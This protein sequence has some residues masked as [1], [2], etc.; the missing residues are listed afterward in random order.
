MQDS[1][2]RKLLRLHHSYWRVSNGFGAIGTTW[3]D[4]LR[5]IY[6]LQRPSWGSGNCVH[7]ICWS[8]LIHYWWGSAIAPLRVPLCKPSA[9]NT[10]HM[11]MWKRC[12][13]G[14]FLPANTLIAA[15]SRLSPTFWQ[16]LYKICTKDRR[17]RQKGSRSGP[18]VAFCCEEVLP[19]QDCYSSSRSKPIQNDSDLP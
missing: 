13:C 2:H 19:T 16:Q 1:C 11:S 4:V 14:L 5:L 7:R 3:V 10:G 12:S 9:Q 15:E 8:R 6:D 18:H 17:K